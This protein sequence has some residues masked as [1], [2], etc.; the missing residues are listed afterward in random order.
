MGGLSPSSASLARA[1]RSPCRC[2]SSQGPA[3]SP[4]PLT[5]VMLRQRPRQGAS[6]LMGME[7][8]TPMNREMFRMGPWAKS[9]GLA[10]LATG[11]LLAGAAWGGLAS[12][13]QASAPP[14]A[15]ASAPPIVHS[16]AAGRDSY[17][18]VVKVVAPAVVTIR[19]EGKAA[20]SPTM[21]QDDDQLRRFFGDQF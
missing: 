1:A 6:R 9:T 18:D 3:R 19:V 2:L 7:E 13:T 4:F 8:Q 5:L 12:I 10:L 14:T 15:A 17:A 11:V 21:F 16:V 20:M